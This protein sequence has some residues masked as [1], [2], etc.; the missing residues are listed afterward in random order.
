MYDNFRQYTS[1]FFLKPDMLQRIIFLIK[2]DGRY[3]HISS[4]GTIFPIENINP[5]KNDI[6]V[7]SEKKLTLTLEN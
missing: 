1:I 4:V 6:F 3:V 5:W 7:A 2:I